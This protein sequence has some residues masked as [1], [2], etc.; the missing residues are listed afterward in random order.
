[1]RK[2]ARV[3]MVARTNDDGQVN[4][5]E[6]IFKIIR[7]CNIEFDSE[8]EEAIDMPQNNG[9]ERNNHTDKQ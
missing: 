7:E 6:R 3:G 4:T 1:M 5:V 2:E 9:V 8:D